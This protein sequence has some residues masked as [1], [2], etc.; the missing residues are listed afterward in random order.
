MLEVSKVNRTSL[1][2]TTMTITAV[3]DIWAGTD[4][5]T[6]AVERLGNTENCKRIVLDLQFAGY[7]GFLPR[8]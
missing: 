2:A 3:V 1:E 7:L 6:L 4:V 5:A 8:R